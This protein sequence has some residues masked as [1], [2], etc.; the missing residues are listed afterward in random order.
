MTTMKVK[1]NKR[2]KNC[3]IKRKLKFS[4]Y[5]FCLLLSQLENKMNYP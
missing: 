1:K 3:L 4:Y 2:Y 5:K